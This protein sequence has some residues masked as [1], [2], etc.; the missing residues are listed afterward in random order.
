MRM[1]CPCCGSRVFE[2]VVPEGELAHEMHL[3]DV[4]AVTRSKNRGNDQDLQDRTSFTHDKAVDLIACNTCGLLVR[5]ELDEDFTEV[6]ANDRYDP[7]VLDQ[8]LIRDI[9]FFSQKQDPYATLL[10]PGA[11]VV[12]IGSYAGGFLHVATSWGWQVEGIDIGEDAARFANSRGYRTYQVTLEERAYSDNS[13]DGL[14]IWNCFDQ[15]PNPASTLLE[16]FRILK[17]GGPIV[18]RTPNAAFYQLCRQELDLSGETADVDLNDHAMTR[19]LGYNN[20]LGFPY[21]FGF[22]PSNLERLLERTGFTKDKLLP[23]QLMAI[24]A[25]ESPDW[26]QNEAKETSDLLTSL[27]DR[28]SLIQPELLISPWMELI[29]IKT[30]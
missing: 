18:I 2:L 28:F 5:D 1:E 4:F 6:Y 13:L 20:L 15:L 8:F 22:S 26:A 19:I 29:A 14:F 7:E 9:A 30:G 12:E 27:A 24:P 3:R 16:A 10:S 17:Q 21:Q 11:R 23:S 25:G